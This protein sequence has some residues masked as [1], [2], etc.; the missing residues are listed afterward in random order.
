MFDI[1]H[2][3]CPK[4]YTTCKERSTLGTLQNIFSLV[5]AKITIIQ[6]YKQ[7]TVVLAFFNLGLSI[8]LKYCLCCI[9]V[10]PSYKAL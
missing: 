1:I 8:H 5:K 9:V 10:C 7:H 2:F 3:S 6:I 4:F